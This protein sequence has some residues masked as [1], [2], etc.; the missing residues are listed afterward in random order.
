MY[1]N[2]FPVLFLEIFA[3]YQIILNEMLIIEHLTANIIY[4]ATK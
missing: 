1:F 3:M 4:V 2:I